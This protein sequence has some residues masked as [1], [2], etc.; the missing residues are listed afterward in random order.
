MNEIFSGDTVNK[1]SWLIFQT[2]RAK[3][4]DIKAKCFMKSLFSFADSIL[5]LITST[6]S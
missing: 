2:R 3:E 5:Q 4:C 1:E 6:S